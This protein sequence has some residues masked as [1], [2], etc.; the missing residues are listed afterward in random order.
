MDQIELQYGSLHL[1]FGTISYL[2]LTT[3]D[4]ERA[5]C[6]GVVMQINLTQLASIAEK[7]KKFFPGRFDN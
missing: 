6:N 7:E 4:S 2:S 3:C 1:K 5:C